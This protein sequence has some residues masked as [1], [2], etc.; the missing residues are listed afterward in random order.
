MTS[1]YVIV[2][3][4]DAGYLGIDVAGLRTSLDQEE[5]IFEVP[6]NDLTYEKDP[7]CRV[8]SHQAV[9]KY[10]NSPEAKGIWWDDA[11]VAGEEP[12]PIEDSNDTHTEDLQ[13]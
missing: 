13:V 12:K 7:D 6:A 1:K 8:F 11:D 3:V 9:L 2:S 10:L 4:D 5:V